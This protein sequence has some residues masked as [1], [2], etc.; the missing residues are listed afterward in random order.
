MLTYFSTST[1]QTELIATEFAQS[2]KPGDVIAY[3]GGLGAG[4]TA[5]TRGL[6]LGLQVRGEVSSPTFALV[7]E[8]KG[9]PSLYHFDMYRIQ[10]LDDV[11]STGYFD[12]LDLHEIIAVEWSENVPELF[13][14]HTIYIELLVTGEDTRTINIFTKKGGQRI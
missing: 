2:L 8:Y 7:H 13:D 3:C 12:Y 6:A 4:K 11:H 5:F 14:E 9:T 10:T 1:K